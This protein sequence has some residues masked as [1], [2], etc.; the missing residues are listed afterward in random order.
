MYKLAALTAIVAAAPIE[1][2]K[3]T[4][5]LFTI[6]LK[7][8]EVEGLEKHGKALK[9]ESMKYEDQMM[10]SQHGQ[11]F[12]A[13]GKA[14]VHTKEF[15]ALAKFVEAMK[16]K[17]PTE[18]M[19][20]VKMAY[21]AQIHKVEM[22]HKKLQAS[23]AQNSKMVG[24]EPHQRL[25]INMNDD[26]WYAFNKEYYKMREMEYYIGYKVPEVVA[27]RGK[28]RSLVETGEFEQIENHWAQ[29]TQQKQHQVVVHHQAKLI[30]EAVKTL[31][32]S[33]AEEKWLDPAVSPVMFDAWHIVYCY[34][35]AVGKGDLEPMLDFMIDGEYDEEFVNAVKPKFPAPENY[36]ED[37]YLF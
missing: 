3:Q 4:A 30:T 13:E 21:M 23:T 34:F 10:H 24:Q 20:K 17:G 8:E 9:Y 18:Q 22:A 25:I 15:V 14:L 5:E 29:V 31:H 2:Y 35:I 28:V 6:K 26:E 36:P 1:E 11:Q 12:Q 7:Q 32:M 16:K 27:V 37:L 19:K 33:K